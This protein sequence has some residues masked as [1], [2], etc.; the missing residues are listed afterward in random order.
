MSKF[1]VGDSAEITVDGE[2][3]TRQAHA[4]NF[5]VGEVVEIVSIHN[6]GGDSG[7]STYSAKDK[8]GISWFI[9]DNCIKPCKPGPPSKKL[10][11]SDRVVLTGHTRGFIVKVYDDG[12]H[13]CTCRTHGSFGQCR[14]VELVLENM[15]DDIIPPDA[16]TKQEPIEEEEEELTPLE[17]IK[18]NAKWSLK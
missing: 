7:V 14:H 15:V 17:K 11:F 16:N 1:K 3:A 10:I 13:S 5:E 9:D 8:D 18:L 6:N 12:T 2:N 4:H